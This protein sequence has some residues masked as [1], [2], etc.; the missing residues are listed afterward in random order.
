[1]V[2]KSK[3]IAN[4][5]AKREIVTPEDGD[6]VRKADRLRL[7]NALQKKRCRHCGQYVWDV[8]HTDGEIRSLKC[9]GCGATAKLVVTRRAI[10]E[11]ESPVSEEGQEDPE[12][13]AGTE[14]GA[15]PAA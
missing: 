11:P 6:Q 2:K 7:D 15:D 4:M 13:E 14:D 8:T 3:K 10:A 9:R 12:A 1:M 5:V